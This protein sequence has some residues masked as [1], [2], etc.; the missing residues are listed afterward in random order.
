MFT[1]QLAQHV[2][3]NQVGVSHR[4]LMIHD[5]LEIFLIH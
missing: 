1:L 3:R 4:L 2:L 5:D